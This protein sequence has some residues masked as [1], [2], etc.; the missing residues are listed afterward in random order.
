MQSQAAPAPV[1]DETALRDH[2][3]CPVCAVPWNTHTDACSRHA[4]IYLHACVGVTPSG[5]TNPW[6]Y[7]SDVDWIP[8]AAGTYL[9]FPSVINDSAMSW[10]IDHDDLKVWQL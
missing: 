6:C 1:R 5:G 9:E 2:L 3:R 8:H 7:Q 10:T 4:F